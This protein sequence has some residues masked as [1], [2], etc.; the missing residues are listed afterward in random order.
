MQSLND[1]RSPGFA[2]VDRTADW[3]YQV[4]G[5]TLAELFIQ[6][7]IA[8]YALAGVHLETA[9]PVVRDIDLQGI[10]Y[11]SLLVA[12]LNELLYLRESE[13]LGFD[14]FE[15]LQLDPQHLKVQIQG[16]PVRSWSK[17]IKW[18]RRVGFWWELPRAIAY[19]LGR[20]VTVRD[21]S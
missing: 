3:A 11:E 13:N 16:A 19:P 10:D 20:A 6:A 18:E 17:F 7:A 2:E 4:W 21:G 15:I 9:P 1:S 8:L 5:E 14:R 12:W